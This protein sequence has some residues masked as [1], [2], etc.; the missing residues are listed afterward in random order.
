MSADE[1]LGDFRGDIIHSGVHPGLPAQQAPLWT[2][3]NN[4]IFADQSVKVAPTQAPLYKK[5]SSLPGTGILA[6]NNNGAPALIWGTRE[7]LYRGLTQPGTADVTR[8][9]ATPGDND[10]TGGDDNL[11]S[12]AQFGNS[13]LAT[14]GVDAVQYLANIASSTNFV[15]LN[16]VSDLRSDFR[17]EIL[18]KTAAFVI[19]YNTDNIDT[20]YI[21]CDEDDVTKWVPDSPNKA[22]DMNIRELASHI[23]CV[24][25]LG[26]LHVVYGHDQAFIVGFSGAPFF[27]D[28]QHLLSGIG[29]VGKHS[30]V[31]VGRRNFGFGP[32]GIFV[33]DGASYTYIDTPSIHKYIYEDHYD[34]ARGA[35]VVAWADANEE[36]AYFSFPTIGGGGASVGVNWRTGGWALFDWYRKAASSGGMWKHPVLIDATGQTWIQSAS[37][38]PYASS[39]VPI[40]LSD[41]MDLTTRYGHIGYGE[42]G[43]GGYWTGYDG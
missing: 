19:A 14:N 10:Y 12:F 29:A 42:G 7:K 2:D 26:R 32:N 22:R 41:W 24:V 37:S 27:F 21:W 3:S 8:Y 9:T 36:I 23:V 13:V 20:E 15:D 16:T 17:C 34:S 40:G 6:A 25:E 31:S 30:I 28:H 43:Y 4:V 33:V 35:E 38:E 5:L 18:R 39:G 11:W 1:P